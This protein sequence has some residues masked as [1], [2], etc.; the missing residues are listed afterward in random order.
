MATREVAGW[1]GGRAFAYDP[2]EDGK[3]R[4]LCLECDR[5]FATDTDKFR[6]HK[7]QPDPKESSKTSKAASN[8]PEGKE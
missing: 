7:C 4:W 2:K 8:T 1:I 3:P 5:H 6:D